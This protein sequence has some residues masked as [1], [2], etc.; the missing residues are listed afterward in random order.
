MGTTYGY[1]RI[2]SP[3]QNI[4]QQI[5][6]IKAAYPSALIIPERVHWDKDEP[7]KLDKAHNKKVC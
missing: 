2:S 3:K 4:E 6:N 5:R 1:V 7:S